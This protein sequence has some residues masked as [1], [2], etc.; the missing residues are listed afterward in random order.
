MERAGRRV[1]PFHFVLGLKTSFSV[2]GS[3]PEANSISPLGNEMS[4]LAKI[5][6]LVPRPSS[7]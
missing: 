6:V 5:K 4:K 1:R 3:V 7:N 2:K